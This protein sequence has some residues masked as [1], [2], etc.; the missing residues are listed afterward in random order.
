MIK[1][2]SAAIFS[3]SC[4]QGIQIFFSDGRTC[5]CMHDQQHVHWQLVCIHW[6]TK[7]NKYID[8]FNA[9]PHIYYYQKKQWHTPVSRTNWSPGCSTM[10]PILPSTLFLSR[11]TA[12]TAAPKRPLNPAARMEVSFK[13]PSS[14]RVHCKCVYVCISSTQGRTLTQSFN[15]ISVH[16]FDR[17][18]T[19]IVRGGC[20]R[21][22]M[23]LF[24]AC[25]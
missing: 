7:Q 24:F 5:I 20:L 17:V 3:G 8:T 13:S 1:H 4:I 11:R 23:G 25:S 19:Q 22:K 16:S 15:I 10:S 6:R 2:L 21:P 18:S 12:T 14:L 9:R